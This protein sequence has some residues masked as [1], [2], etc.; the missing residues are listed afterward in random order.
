MHA[1]TC[2]GRDLRKTRRR[3]RLE[4]ANNNNI[5]DVFDD[6]ELQCPGI[7]T[8][9]WPEGP[10]PPPR[11][12]PR[13]NSVHVASLSRDRSSS[14]CEKGRQRA[15]FGSTSNL[16]RYVVPR[17]RSNSTRNTSP[18]FS[19]TSCS[20]HELRKMIFHKRV[21]QAKPVVRRSSESNLASLKEMPNESTSDVEPYASKV[22]SAFSEESVERPMANPG[23]EGC[24]SNTLQPLSAETCSPTTKGKGVDRATSAARGTS[25]VEEG[26]AQYGS[27]SPTHSAT[28]DSDSKESENSWVEA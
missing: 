25:S 7:S 17:P 19:R 26:R 24:I 2:C 5:Y 18:G 21:D 23:G 20:D 28:S 8:P 15:M 16:S 22:R 11:Y 3:K 14:S 27:D 10:T 9:T 4:S 13:A 12:Q 6:V 1:K